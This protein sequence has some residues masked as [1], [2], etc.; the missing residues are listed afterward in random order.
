MVRAPVGGIYF[1]AGQTVGVY[2]SR[3]RDRPAL[4]M[5][6]RW[7]D[8]RCVAKCST[9]LDCCR[10]S[11]GVSAGMVEIRLTVRTN[12]IGFSRCCAD[13]TPRWSIAPSGSQFSGYMSFRGRICFA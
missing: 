1:C 10:S 9:T 12:S 2:W 13:A 8:E 3:R 4:L 11:S 7:M 5:Q 6:L